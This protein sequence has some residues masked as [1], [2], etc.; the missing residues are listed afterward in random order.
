[1]NRSDQS[2]INQLTS[3]YSPFSPPQLPL[4]FSDYLS[5]VWRI[6]R[7]AAQPN[8]V[9][10]YIQ[11]ARALARAFQFE[12]RSIGRIIR[13]AEPGQIY[14]SLGL[15][16][17]QSTG[18]LMDA[19]ARKS[20][21]DQLAQLRADVLAIGA[22]QHDWVVGWPGSGVLDPDLRERIFAT[23]FTALRSQYS[24]FG[25][26]LLVIDIVLQEMLLGKRNLSEFSLGTLIDHYGYPDPEDPAIR[27]LYRSETGDWQT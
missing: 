22:Y 25:R 18:R 10:Y 3:P 11:C 23:L 12:Q 21:I 24:H 15:A 1:M 2:R 14:Q 7:H 26:L 4:D 6:D 8:L 16:P 20:A 9:R 27:E 5:L 13:Q 17:F 19:A